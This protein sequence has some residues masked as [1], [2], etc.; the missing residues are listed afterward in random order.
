MDTDQLLFH[1]WMYFFARAMLCSQQKAL[2]LQ[3]GSHAVDWTRVTT[4]RCH[5]Q[6]LHK[7]SLLRHEGLLVIQRSQWSPSTTDSWERNSH[8]LGFALI[9]CLK[10][11]NSEGWGIS[12]FLMHRGL[13][14]TGKI[15]LW[16]FLMPVLPWLMGVQK[17]E[18]QFQEHRDVTTEW[19]RTSLVYYPLWQRTISIVI[20]YTEI[21]SSM[22]YMV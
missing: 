10:C 18:K 13:L 15:F 21:V 1:Y 2:C 3:K 11:G 4:L 6:S 9:T 22:S 8:S 7:L 19:M 16:V 5:Q 12:F 14:G 20:F 17:E